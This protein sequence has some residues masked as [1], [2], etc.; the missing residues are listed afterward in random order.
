MSETPHPKLTSSP[1]YLNKKKKSESRSDHFDMQN[2]A[3]PQY[4]HQLKNLLNLIILLSGV[5]NLIRIT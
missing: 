2:E 5:L 3:M 4:I 1:T